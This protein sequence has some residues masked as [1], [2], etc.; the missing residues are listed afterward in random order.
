MRWVSLD[1]V[2]AVRHRNSLTKLNVDTRRARTLEKA[3]RE[4]SKRGDRIALK[5]PRARRS[6]QQLP[7]LHSRTEIT[8]DLE[9]S[10]QIRGHYPELAIEQVSEDL[11][12]G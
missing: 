8:A 12:R 7:E 2:I 10:A 6:R 1:R 3:Q 4:G 5:R 9:L 11:L